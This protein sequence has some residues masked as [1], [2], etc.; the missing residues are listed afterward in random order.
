METD[1]EEQM[2]AR[3][4]RWRDGGVLFSKTFPDQPIGLAANDVARQFAEDRIRD[5]VTTGGRLGPDP[6]R[7]PDRHEANLH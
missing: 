6:G 1:P 5:I 7:P 4:R 3:W 2:E